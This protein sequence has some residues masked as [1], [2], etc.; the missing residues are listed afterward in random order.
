MSIFTAHTTFVGGETALAQAFV[1]AVKPR[2]ATAA[3]EM[4][5]DSKDLITA[6][7]P[8]GAQSGRRSEPLSSRGNYVVSIAEVPQGYVIEWTVQGSS[9]FLAKFHAQNS[10]S[11]P[12]AIT[13]AR[14]MPFPTS[15]D[16]DAEF[17]GHSAHHPGTRGTH[18]YDRAIEVVLSRAQQY[19]D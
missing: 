19:L 3:R 8:V 6:N 7:A 10:G 11:R 9:A 15:D 16:A 18:F 2:F 13:S 5:Q 14:K 12:H 4:S 1:E 17:F